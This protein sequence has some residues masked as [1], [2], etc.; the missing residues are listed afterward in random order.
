MNVQYATIRIEVFAEDDTINSDDEYA[1]SNELSE[2]AD[3][4]EYFLNDLKK[5][6]SSFHFAVFED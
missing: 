4:I 1:L 5:R 3:M 6:G 2:V